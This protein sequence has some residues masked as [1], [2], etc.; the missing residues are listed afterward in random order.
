VDGELSGQSPLTLKD[1]PVGPIRVEV[2]D[3]NRGFQKEQTFVLNAGDNGT[4]TINVGVGTLEVKVQPYATV[5]LDGRVLGPAPLQPTQVYEG[6]HVLR[7]VNKALEKDVTLDIHV[8]P[9]QSTVIEKNL[10]TVA[11]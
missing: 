9:D 4:K 11:N 7:L 3:R 6:R 1:R 2:F 8:Q 5:L 10:A